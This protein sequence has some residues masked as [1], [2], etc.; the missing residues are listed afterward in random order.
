MT[1]LASAADRTLPEG[2][3]AH[4]ALAVARVDR[5]PGLPACPSMWDAP[6]IQLY[7]LRSTSVCPLRRRYIAP[8]CG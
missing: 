8:P 6:R 5:R 3:S 2:R 4:Q 1:A 7:A